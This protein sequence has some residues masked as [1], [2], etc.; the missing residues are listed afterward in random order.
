MLAVLQQ[1][2]RLEG[3]STT[4]AYYVDQNAQSIA[5]MSG[6]LVPSNQQFR[7]PPQKSP[8]VK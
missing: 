5:Q 1:L 3:I 2:M 8:A 4:T 6:R 7:Q